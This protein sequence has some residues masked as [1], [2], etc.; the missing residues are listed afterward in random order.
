MKKVV[1]AWGRMNPVTV[2]HE[3]LVNKVQ[4]VARRE[5]A[6]PRIYLSHTQN[7]KKD[8]LQYKDKIAMAKKAFGSVVK[9]SASKTLIQLLQELQRAGFTEITLVAGSDRLREY[10]TLLNKYNG[11]DYN[12]DKIKVVSAGERD[13]DAEGA[14]GMSATKL[15][16]AAVDGD[17]KTFMTGIPSRLSKTDGQKL[18]M[19]IRKGLMVE[20]MSK[21]LEEAKKKKDVTDKDFSDTELDKAVSQ[22]EEE[23]DEE[24]FDIDLEEDLDEEYLEERAPLT[25]QQRIKR[26]RQMKRMAPKMS[27]LRKLRKFR[28]APTERLQQRAKKLARNLMRKKLGGKKGESYAKLSSAEKI[29]IDKLVQTKT[30]VIDRLAKRLLPKVK[31]AELERIRK[32]RQTK[33]ESYEVVFE[34]ITAPQDKDIADRKGTQPAKYHKGLAPST[35]A[36]RDAQFKKQAKMADDDPKAYKPAPGDKR[37]ETKPSKYTK[38]YKDMFG[39]EDALKQAREKIKQEKQQDKQ[40]HDR[41]LDRARMQ[42]ARSNMRTATRKNRGVS[43]ATSS[44]T[45]EQ[46]ELTEK[47]ASALQQKA[48]KSGISVGT[49]NKV[50][51]RGVAAWKTGHRPGTTPQQWGYARVNA[52]IAKKKKGTLNHDKDLA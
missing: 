21:F 44:T 25:L 51:N 35:K 2:G 37:A 34:K 23:F 24:D 40:K 33:N 45:N 18:Y 28:L 48:E 1:F 36:A 14:S 10:D 6:E 31:K 19:L 15:R 46:F 41:T 32:A 52:F 13:P 27:R 20:E 50:Y 22:M 29:S 3:K 4:A 12:F 5:R 49:L 43:S 11:K 39:E 26:A 17:E 7:A 47:S 8:P 9:Q 42:D 38:M 16:K 30:A